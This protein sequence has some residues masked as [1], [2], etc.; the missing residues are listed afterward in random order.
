MGGRGSKS[1][2][3]A[4]G[5]PYGSE[6][7]TVL[8]SGNIKFVVVNEGQNNAP[9]ETMTEGRIYATVDKKTNELK[10]ISYYDKHNERFKQID[11]Q[12]PHNINGIMTQPHTHLGYFHNEKGYRDL[13]EKEKKMVD[14]II[15]TWYNKSNS[16]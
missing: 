7:T 2:V 16:K 3:S 5:K 6:F 11:L 4:K 13:T 14:R 10:Y 9:M 15:K 12:H 1:G 8:K